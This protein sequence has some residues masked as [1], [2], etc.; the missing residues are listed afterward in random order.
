MYQEYKDKLFQSF[1]LHKHFLR[2]SIFALASFFLRIYWQQ[3]RLRNGSSLRSHLALMTLVC[4]VWGRVLCTGHSP[5]E[6]KDL[7]PVK[8]LAGNQVISSK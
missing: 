2:P 7:N 8:D 3:L 5:W 6:S 1:R 4:M